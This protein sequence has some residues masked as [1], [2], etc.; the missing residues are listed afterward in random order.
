MQRLVFPDALSITSPIMHTTTITLD[1]TTLHSSAT[2]FMAVCQYHEVS[3]CGH[4]M[5]AKARQPTSR[6]P[7]A[8]GPAW[9][10]PNVPRDN[11]ASP[12]PRKLDNI[13]IFDNLGIWNCSLQRSLH[14][15]MISLPSR[16][17]SSCRFGLW[18][19]PRAHFPDR[20]DIAG[21]CNS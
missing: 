6:S 11:C 5:S 1:P 2:R 9:S 19:Y 13:E 7:P 12:S 15:V 21:N 10:G 18:S 20:C 17:V 3:L 14:T 8:C 16:T 4:Y